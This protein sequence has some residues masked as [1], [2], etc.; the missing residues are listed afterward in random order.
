MDN[1]FKNLIDS[2]AEHQE[3]L[4]LLPTKPY[5]DQVA[6][7]LSLYLSLTAYKKNVSVYS[8]VPATAEFSRLVGVNK[9]T[10]DLGKKNLTIKFV[11]YKADYIEKVSY[12][13]DGEIFKLTVT[14]KSSFKA[15]SKE[16]IH[17]DYSGI[18]ADLAILV[19]GANESHFPVLQNQEFK[20]IKIIHVGTR[21]LEI[22][23]D[24]QVLSFARP[25]SSTSEI[26]AGLIKESGFP[27]DADIATNL[28]AGIE[29]QSKNFQSPEVTADTFMVFA[30]LLKTG[31]KRL[32]KVIPQKFPQGAIPTMPYS[33]KFTPQENS[34]INQ[35][36]EEIPIPEE[37]PHDIPP[38][39]SE[40]KIFTGTNIS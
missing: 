29:E 13:V 21:L 10:S 37:V 20:N 22:S 17:L 12:D 8:H 27:F 40:P 23:S 6:S 38:T 5:L 30:E 33:Q 26:V 11:D 3:I 18:S 35:V 4:V 28:I 24:L 19:G 39:W 31:G 15:P 25:A 32:P 2:I 1:S 16:Q 14:P 9:I 36:E 34:L 7:A